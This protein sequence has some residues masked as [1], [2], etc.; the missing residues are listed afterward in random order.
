MKLIDAINYDNAEVL[1]HALDTQEVVTI[2]KGTYCTSLLK[3]EKSVTLELKEGAI[4]K[5]LPDF[6][7][8]KP[9]YTRWEGIMCYAMQPCLL[10]NNTCKVTICGDGTIDG[11]GELWWKAVENKR[12][13]DVSPTSEIE[14]QFAALNPEYLNQEGGGGGRLSQFLRPPLLQIKDCDEITIKGITLTNSPFWTLHP[15]FS[16][17]LTIDNIKIINPYLAPNTDGIDVD[18]CKRVSISNCFVQVGDDGICLKSGSGKDGS[19]VGYKTEDIKVFN[20]CVEHAHGG[21]VIG[22]ETAAGIENVLFDHC[23]FNNTDRG[24]RIKSRRGRGGALKNLTFKNITM[25]G[26]LA[27]FVINLYYRCGAK[28]TSFFSLEKQE[29]NEQTPRVENVYLENC[30]SIDSLASAGMIVGLPESPIENVVLK[31]CRFTIKE[32]S[33]TDVDETDMYLGLPRIESR[34][35]RI[36]NANVKYENLVIDEPLVIEEGVKVSYK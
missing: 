5:F 8:Y 6:S 30:V 33:T 32:D 15:L 28:D 21:G 20:C 19:K 9:F 27:P 11:S 24:I 13:G 3:I 25:K 7:L 14:K 23:L 4:L 31:N 1:Q 36:R 26:N 18:S 22:S 17:N 16:T 12:G 34:G 2:E 35:L 29:V 10:I